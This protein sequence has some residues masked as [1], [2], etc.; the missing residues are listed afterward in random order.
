MAT[1]AVSKV[2]QGFRR[3]VLVRDGAD[4]TDGQLLGRFI[5]QRD[6]AA[7]E[8]LVRRHGAMIMGICRR[9]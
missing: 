9:R 5:E 2:L 6:E 3:A 4:Q 8:A 1:S 7:F